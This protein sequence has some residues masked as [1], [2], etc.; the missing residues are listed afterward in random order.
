MGASG[1]SIRNRGRRTKVGP[2]EL[3]ITSLLDILVILL[4]FLL[5]SYNSSGVSFNT[6]SIQLPKSQSSSLNNAGV[7]VT[8]AKDKIWV[9][10]KAI[11]EGE[12]VIR[13]SYDMGG[14]RIVPL[15]NELVKKKQTIER[16]EKSAPN[17]AKFSGIINLLVDKTIK[18]T[19]LKKIMFTCAEAGFRQYKFVVLGENQ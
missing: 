3:D 1:R 16:V 4:V 17:A 7:I 14:R 9:D 19:Y 12:S 8:V 15:F 5:K 18:Y 13:T 11:L 10:D 6:K 2:L